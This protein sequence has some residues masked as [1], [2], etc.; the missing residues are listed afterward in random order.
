[1]AVRHCK[2]Y[3]QH[4][5]PKAC[6]LEESLSSANP[7]K[8]GYKI[9]IFSRACMSKGSRQCGDYDVPLPAR[10]ARVQTPVAGR[11]ARGSHNSPCCSLMMCV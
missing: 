4:L 7:K 11:S 5:N 3:T 8:E 1:M 10:S 2:S 6:S 9:M